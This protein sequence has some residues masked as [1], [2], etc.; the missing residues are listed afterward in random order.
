MGARQVTGLLRWGG[1]QSSVLIR[2]Q[3]NLRP[4]CDLED[5]RV[6]V[7]KMLRDCGLRVNSIQIRR[8]KMMK[9]KKGKKKK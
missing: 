4:G 2:V 7:E 6:E 9:K 5:L 3:G 8:L 1:G